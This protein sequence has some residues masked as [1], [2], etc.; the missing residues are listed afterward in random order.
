[1]HRPKVIP[2]TGFQAGA[3][4]CSVLFAG[5]IRLFAD[6]ASTPIGAIFVRLWNAHILGMF[7]QRKIPEIFVSWI[8]VAY[9]GVS[10]IAVL[11][12]G[13]KL[14]RWVTG[15]PKSRPVPQG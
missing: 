10:A 14:A 6:A 13:L 5:A 11:L 15:H 2:F 12:V 7:S 3:F 9:E 1:M 4:I 8:M